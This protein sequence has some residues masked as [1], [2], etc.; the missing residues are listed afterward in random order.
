MDLEL[1]DRVALVTGAGRG[2]GHA[3]ATELAREGVRIV[4]NDIDA[5]CAE[6][7]AARI[8]EVGVSALAAPGD[9][10]DPGDVDAIVARTV[11]AFGR[12]D[13]LVNNAGVGGRVELA[14]RGGRP[15]SQRKGEAA[16]HFDLQRRFGCPSCRG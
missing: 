5:A 1:R 16:A 11:G 10:T 6:A 13:I 15:A 3:E 2:I 14:A 9:V 12:L 8:A 7:G 4:V